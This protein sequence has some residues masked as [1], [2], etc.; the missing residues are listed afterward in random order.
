M[1]AI[2]EAVHLHRCL[3]DDFPAKHS[4]LVSFCHSISSPSVCQTRCLAWQ[5]KKHSACK[6][7]WRPIALPHS[8]LVLLRPLTSEGFVDGRLVELCAARIITTLMSMTRSWGLKALGKCLKATVVQAVVVG[9]SLSN[10][11][12]R[13]QVSLVPTSEN[14]RRSEPQSSDCSHFGI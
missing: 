13:S 14:S 10:S 7:I 9:S 5:F 6:D 3:G 11:T 1:Q 4:T 2:Q 8:T 12:D